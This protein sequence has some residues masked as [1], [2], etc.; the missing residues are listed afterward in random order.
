MTYVLNFHSISFCYLRPY[1][2]AVNHILY[3]ESRMFVVVMKNSLI[4]LKT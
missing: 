4:A 1:Q 2:I 3:N